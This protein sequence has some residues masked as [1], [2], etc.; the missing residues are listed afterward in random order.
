MTKDKP[1]DHNYDHFLAQAAPDIID[2]L[3]QQLATVTQE[4]DALRG[5]VKTIQADLIIDHDWQRC[6]IKTGK[7]EIDLLDFIDAELEALAQKAET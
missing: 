7:N 3:K 4:R 6:V 1:K 5:L 2:S